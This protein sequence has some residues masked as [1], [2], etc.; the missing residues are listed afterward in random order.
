MDNSEQRSVLYN[1]TYTSNAPLNSLG[2]PAKSFLILFANW[3]TAK[4][5]PAPN[6]KFIADV[7]LVP[8]ERGDSAGG[9]SKWRSPAQ[10]HLYWVHTLMLSGRVNQKVRNRCVFAHYAM[11][12]DGLSSTKATEGSSSPATVM[13]SRRAEQGQVRALNKCAKKTGLRLCTP[14]YESEVEHVHRT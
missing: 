3:I 4:K 11:D 2:A 6:P 13:L 10:R 7:F 12:L 5:S 8:P 14:P 1:A 9:N